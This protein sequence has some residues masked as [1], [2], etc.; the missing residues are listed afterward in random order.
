V[1]IQTALLS[2]VDSEISRRFYT[3]LTASGPTHETIVLF[4]AMIWAFYHAHARPM[5]WRETRDPYAILV[6]EVMLQQTQVN[7]V[8]EKYPDFIGTF[9]TFET[10][11]AAPL[12][13]VLDQ[14]QGLGYNRRAVA[15]H[16]AAGI[17]VADWGGHLKEDPAD[18]VT[19]PGIG[20]ATAASIAAFAFNRPTV[21]IETNIRRVFIHCFCA[22][23]DGVTDGE[24]LPLV[25]QTL[26][27]ENSR[28]WYY[29]LMDFGTFIAANHPNPNRKSAHYSKQSRFEGS[30]R[31]VRGRILRLLGVGPSSSDDLIGELG[32]D[33]ARVDR[34]LLALQAEG[35]LEIE[36][37]LV[38]IRL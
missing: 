5:A 16:R 6:S 33:P 25:E 10:L 7:R 29:A 9:P 31:Q 8:K 14:W 36:G 34:L 22:D 19:L 13:A 15:L 17:V 12:S 20:K 24:I 18:L 35:F 37:E 1:E 3:A 27:R 32:E 4:Q 38:R 28:E 11:A 26:D 21:F 30:D 23:R 2:G